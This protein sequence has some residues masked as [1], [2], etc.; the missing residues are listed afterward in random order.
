MSE[1]TGKH[2]GLVLVLAFGLLLGAGVAA[3][4][5]PVSAAEEA[6]R[7]GCM[8]RNGSGDCDWCSATC[9]TNQVCCP[10]GS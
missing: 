7:K 10:I 8:Q 3:T 9:A 6:P 4:A 1:K 5:S 2:R